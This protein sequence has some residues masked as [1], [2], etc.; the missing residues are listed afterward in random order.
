MLHFSHPSEN[1][2]IEKLRRAVIDRHLT[3]MVNC[4]AQHLNHHSLIQSSRFVQRDIVGHYNLEWNAERPRENG[5]IRLWRFK[6]KFSDKRGLKKGEVVALDY[7]DTVWHLRIQGAT[8]LRSN[9]D[10]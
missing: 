4:L 2:S 9:H 6:I 7:D 10:P 8:R 3:L 1:S 5:G